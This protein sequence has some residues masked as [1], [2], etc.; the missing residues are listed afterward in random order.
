[1]HESQVNIYNIISYSIEKIIL[2]IRKVSGIHILIGFLWLY[3]DRLIKTRYFLLRT[4]AK[5]CHLEIDKIYVVPL[6]LQLIKFFFWVRSGPLFWIHRSWCL[7]SNSFGWILPSKFFWLMSISGFRWYKQVHPLPQYSAAPNSYALWSCIL[8]VYLFPLTEVPF[9]Q[10][11]VSIGISSY[12][13]SL[14]QTTGHQICKP[15]LLLREW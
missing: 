7:L 6:I 14:R 2:S 1:M 12:S 11:T 13:A 8:L 9:I 3:C 5:G 10:V 4:W 15:M